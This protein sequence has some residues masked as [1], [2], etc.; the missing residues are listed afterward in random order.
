MYKYV[1]HCTLCAFRFTEDGCPHKKFFHTRYLMRMRLT[2][3]CSK[4]LIST[5]SGYLLILHDLDLTQ[6]LEVGS[7]RILRARRA[8]LSTGTYIKHKQ[9]RYMWVGN[10]ESRDLKSGDMEAT[11]DLYSK[12]HIC[13]RQGWAKFR[14][15]RMV[16]LSVH[17]LEFKQNFNWYLLYCVLEIFSTKSFKQGISLIQ[18]H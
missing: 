14:I 6:S 7:Y 2:P 12:V 13:Y 17:E 10:E 16:F 5:S 15:V 18:H 9:M 3:D 8:P 4:M 1:R 11:M